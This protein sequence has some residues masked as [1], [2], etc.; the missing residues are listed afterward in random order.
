MS[1]Y[2]ETREES[3]NLPNYCECWQCNYWQDNGWDVS[4]TPDW[5]L[6]SG[7]DE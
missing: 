3:C 6:P 5:Q 1:Y 7:D 4:C 2:E